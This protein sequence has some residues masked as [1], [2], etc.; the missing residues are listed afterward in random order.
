[1]S[2]TALSECLSLRINSGPTPSLKLPSAGAS[3]GASERTAGQQIGEG[4]QSSMGII[5]AVI[6]TSMGFNGMRDG[7]KNL[8]GA[9]LPAANPNSSW[10]KERERQRKE[11]ASD[12]RNQH[13]GL[14]LEGPKKHASH[15]ND[16]P[17]L[18][19]RDTDSM[20]IS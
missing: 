12:E 2:L 10:A 3:A 19:K 8:E 18:A 13:Y 7:L 6:G 15:A 14:K 17:L 11:F 1:M 16:A 20:K 5:A 4:I 9:K